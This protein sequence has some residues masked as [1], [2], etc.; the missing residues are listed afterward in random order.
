MLNFTAK[1]ANE[2]KKLYFAGSSP[3]NR[4]GSFHDIGLHTVSGG[5]ADGYEKNNLNPG[6]SA[7]RDNRK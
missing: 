7:K 6:N 1:P 5:A 4:P 3:A 2:F